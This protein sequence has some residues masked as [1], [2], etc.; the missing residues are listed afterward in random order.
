MR[1]FSVAWYT[2]LV[3]S[4]GIMLL[5]LGD[6]S[7]ALLL[8]IVLPISCLVSTRGKTIATTS[9]LAMTMLVGGYLSMSPAVDPSMRSGALTVVLM[10]PAV[11]LLILLP[12]WMASMGALHPSGASTDL[13]G[14]VENQSSTKF[15]SDSMAIGTLGRLTPETNRSKAA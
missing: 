8:A 5:V 14:A 2:S 12:A 7:A 1:L 11:G 6:P 15:M 10:A 9:A 4:A 13:S 3:L